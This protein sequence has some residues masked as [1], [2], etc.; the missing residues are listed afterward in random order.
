MK[1]LLAALA[2]VVAVPTAMAALQQPTPGPSAYVPPGWEQHHAVAQVLARGDVVS[3]GGGQGDAV[4]LTF[5]D[6]PGPYTDDVLRVLRRHGARATFFVVG[7]R[8]D[9]WP[10][11]ARQEARLGGVGNHTWS[12]PHLTRLPHWLAWLELMRTQYAVSAKLGWK[13]RLFRTPYAEHSRATDEIVRRLGLVEVFWDVDSRD[14][15]PHARVDDIVRT[16]D[17]SL[18]PGAIVLMHDIHP[19]TLRALPRVLE[20]IESRGLRAVSVPELL[21]LDPPAPDQRCPYP[22]AGPGD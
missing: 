9:Y 10:A 12:H 8:L 4:A 13:P 1:T 15:V 19:W 7:N 5:D 6:G 20:A 11:V 21:A 17:R 16:V 3:C 2:L 18:R 14:D 22:P